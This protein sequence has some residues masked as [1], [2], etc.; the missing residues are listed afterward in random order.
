MGGADDDEPADWE[1]LYRL[2]LQNL[3]WNATEWE[4][5]LWNVTV[6]RYSQSLINERMF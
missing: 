4:S 2:P 1:A 5:G 6:V 3:T